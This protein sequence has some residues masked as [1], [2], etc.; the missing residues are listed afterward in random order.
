MA[1]PY[2]KWLERIIEYGFAENVDFT[3]I[4]KNVHDDTEFG[5]SR[6]IT[7][8]TMKFDMSICL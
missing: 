4:T 1:T 5:G 8:H 3:V 6:K 2:K 7:V